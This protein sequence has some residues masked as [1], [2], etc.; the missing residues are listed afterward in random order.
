MTA[1]TSGTPAALNLDAEEREL[2]RS[3][4]L[5]DPE[6]VLSD[7]M[8][9]RALIGAGASDARNIVDLRDRLV[10]RL[11]GRLKQLVHTN[12]SVI[13]AA[14]E[15]VS[16]TRQLHRAVLSLVDAPDLGEFLRRLTR[17]VPPMVGVEEGRL[18]IE[19]Q[20]DD[21]V[22][23][24]QLVGNLEGRVLLVPEG[25]V[26]EY[27]ALDG[28]PGSGPVA[29]R[30]CGGEAEL[31]FGPGT[32]VRSEALIRLELDTAAGLV[33]FG[34]ADPDRFGAEQGTELLAF[35]GGVVQRLLARHLDAAGVA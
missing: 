26:T 32:R 31:V 13:A 11:E 29:L 27:F 20:V 1:D 25:T 8:V 22:E 34:A 10:E 21:I 4:I 18:C 2:I 5:T 3:L 7:D 30:P 35:F 15:N 23:A 33:A 9:M 12:R 6:I 17:D 16:G 14:Y 28:D 24:Y 19:A